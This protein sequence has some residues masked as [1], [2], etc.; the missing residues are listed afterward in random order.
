MSGPIALTFV[1]SADRVDTHFAWNTG[2]ILFVLP[3]VHALLR[4]KVDAFRRS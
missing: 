1:T 2:E 4:A 3:A